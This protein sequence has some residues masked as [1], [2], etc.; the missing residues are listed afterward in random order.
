MTNNELK[1]EQSCTKMVSAIAT[2][3]P[4]PLSRARSNIPLTTGRAAEEKQAIAW[5]GIAN[6]NYREA[7]DA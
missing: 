4:S 1:F 5:Q 7:T 6:L 2:P 3:R